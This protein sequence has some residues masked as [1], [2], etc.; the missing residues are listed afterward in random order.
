MSTKTLKIILLDVHALLHRAYHALPDF[1]TSKGEATG[2]LYGLATTLIKLSGD[3]HPDYMIACY[4]LPDKTH[5]HEVYADYKAGRA[6]IDQDLIDQINSSRGLFEALR[7]P[8]FESPGFEADDI[9]GTIV[10]M[11]KKDKDKAILIASGDMDT[12]QL[13]DERRVSIFTLKKGI[14]DTVV[15]D[16]EGV[17]NRFGFGPELLPDYKGLRGDPSDN[18]IGVPGIGEKTATILISEFGTLENIFKMME[19]KKAEE[20]EEKLRSAGIS[21]RI[22]GLLKEHKEEALFSKMLATIRRDAPIKFELP[23]KTFKEGLDIKKIE[24]LFSRLEFRVL[25]A[26][27]KSIIDEG[28]EKPH[29][30]K[31]SAVDYELMAEKDLNK[32]AAANKKPGSVKKV[33]AKDGIE[34]ANNEEKLKPEIAVALYLLDSSLAKPSLEDL[35]RIGGKSDVE[36]AEGEVL[37]QI[38]EF[39]L[40]KI[41]EEIEKPL[42]PVIDKMEKRG[43]KIDTDY[44]KDLSKKYHKALSDL[45]KKIWKETGEEFNINSPKQLGEIIFNKMNLKV[46]G[47]KKTAGGAQSTKESELLKLA[48]AH[49]VINLI[50]EYR[51]LQKLLSTYIDVIPGL[52]DE[53][54]RLHAHFIQTGA[55]TGRMAS[56]DP[57]LQ[58]I[59]IKTELGRNIRKAF[60]S[61]KSFVLGAFDY[62]QIELRIAAILSEDEKLMEIFRT[63]QDVHAAVAAQ[64][65]KVPENEVTKEMRRKAKV[66]NFGILYGMGVNA[67]KTNLGG[68][69]DEAKTF[70]DEYFATFTTLASYLER[71]K[72][73]AAGQGYTT[74]LWGRRRYFPDINSRLPYIRAS[75]E[76][77]AIN[78]PI[79]GSQADLIKKAMVE[80]D[81]YI[82]KEK[83]EDCIYLLLQVHDEVIYEIK[84][85]G[86]GGEE[87]I[88]EDILKIMSGIMTK[89]ETKGVP[90]IANASLGTNW[91]EM[92]DLG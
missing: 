28:K 11:T 82:Q 16:E 45:E 71:V 42:L 81:E 84:K 57:N 36:S 87:K 48:D 14:K 55:S 66:I 12:L 31:N 78:A 19:G 83:L 21:E 44:L 6:K 4:D 30:A 47:L 89:E 32:T 60:V 62:S 54:N 69:R 5:R 59:P 65:F 40:E 17:K 50:L 61:E 29:V 13:A 91:D 1:K 74:T 92:R 85:D 7:I 22:I 37:R 70:Y 86:K 49:P 52:V 56:S 53:K 38:K 67:L 18:I 76:R 79:Q 64:V 33:R 35:F 27:F 72:R 34:V 15:Y 39:D 8:I 20:G 51:E 43:V 58:N 90:I 3:F 80:I 77:M 24:D 68:T 41:Y 23:E 46:K 2:A 26:R 25:G 88:A 73:E 63:G 9:L 75:A 10:E